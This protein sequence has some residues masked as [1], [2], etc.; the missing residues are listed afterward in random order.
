MKVNILP[1]IKINTIY[2]QDI[3]DCI[4]VSTC[5]CRCGSQM[6]LTSL[7]ILHFVFWGLFCFVLFFEIRSHSVAWLTWNS[8]CRS[9][10]PQTHRDLPAFQVLGLIKGVCCSCVPCFFETQSL[11]LI[12]LVGYH[13]RKFPEGKQA[14]CPSNLGIYRI[15]VRIPKNTCFQTATEWG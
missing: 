8:L 2:F 1:L 7:I 14:E 3:C 5:S 9:G 10:W 13:T 15:K 4:H 12:A 6:W 11:E